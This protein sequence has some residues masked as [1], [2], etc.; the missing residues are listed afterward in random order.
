MTDIARLGVTF[1][2]GP[3]SSPWSNGIN[4]QNHASCDLTIKKL[5]EERKVALTDSLVNSAAWTN[6]TNVNKL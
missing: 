5:M 4:E 3:A 6:N 1:R 2:Y